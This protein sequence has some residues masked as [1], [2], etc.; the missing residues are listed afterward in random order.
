MLVI[1]WY[2]PNESCLI[3]SVW[4]FTC[5]PLFNPSIHIIPLPKLTIY[6]STS[7]IFVIFWTSPPLQQQFIK[8]YCMISRL[9]FIFRSSTFIPVV[10]L[11]L[12]IIIRYIYSPR[13]F[14]WLNHALNHHLIIATYLVMC[15]LLP[16]I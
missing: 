11:L 9:Y 1:I 14:P 4:H 12:F 2:L 5:T 13:S 15:L 8:I 16:C 10:C 3:F 7:Y 6:W